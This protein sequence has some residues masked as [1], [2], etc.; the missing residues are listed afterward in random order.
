[1]SA[2]DT[3]FA[4]PEKIKKQAKREGAMFYEAPLPENVKNITEEDIPYDILSEMAQE[5]HKEYSSIIKENP[6]MSDEDARSEVIRR[7]PEL[8]RLAQ[9]NWVIWSRFTD[10]NKSEEARQKMLQTILIAQKVTQGQLDPEE[11]KGYVSDLMGV[12][13][14]KRQEFINEM[15]K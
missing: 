4:D 14:D 9:R 13:Y 2:S 12:D 8:A 11:A 7:R 5:S 3:F 10:R 6:E 15:S 1:M